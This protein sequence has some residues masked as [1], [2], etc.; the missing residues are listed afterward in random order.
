MS[1]RRK[2]GVLMVTGA[3]MLGATFPAPVPAWADSWRQVTELQGSDTVANDD[4]GFTIAT[5]HSTIV[6]GADGHAED[7]GRVY[8][9]TQSAHGWHQTAELVGSDTVAGDLFGFSLAAAPGIVVVSGYNHAKHAGRVYVFTEST[10]G[11]HQTAELVGSD[12]VAGDYFG[13]SLAAAPGLIVVG[14]IG[15][16]KDAGRVYVFTKSADGWHQSAELVGSDTVANSG[17]GTSVGASPGTIVV[18]ADGPAKDTG[19][20]YVFT[21]SAHGWHQSAE[22]VGSDTVA[23]DYFGASF[24]TAPGLIVVGAIGHAKYAGRVYVF[25]ESSHGWHQS[26]ELVGSDTVAGDFF[27]ASFA[28]SS[29]TIIVG[30]D[31]HAHDAGRVYVFTDSTHGWH[32]TAELEGSDTVGGDA[33]GLPVG[34]SLGTIVVGADGHAEHAGRVYVFQR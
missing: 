33:F 32:Q 31:G 22:L 29:A 23:G 21:K 10:H 13:T 20:V 8:I 28:A 30:A 25:T 9:F 16:A 11:W 12:T 19:R 26:A 4:F 18:G 15:H 1:S 7:A 24:A 3:A 14:A 2:I 34:A 27:G 6:V 17:F 5:L